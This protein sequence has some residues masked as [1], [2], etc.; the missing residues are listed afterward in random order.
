MH[1]IRY[2]TLTGVQRVGLLDGYGVVRRIAFATMAELLAAPLSE[3]R[4][5]AAEPTEVDEPAALLAP[6]APHTDVW[7]AGVTYLRSR[8]ARVEESRDQD[9]YMRVY[10]AVRPELFPKSVGWR[11]VSDGGSIGIRADSTSDIPEPELGL[12][13]NCRAEIIGYVVCNDVSSRAIEAEN[14]I[15]LPQAKIYA[16]SCA[17][18]NQIRPAWEVSDPRA[19]GIEMVVER[20]GLVVF[21]GMTSTSRMQRTFEDLVDHLFA[22]ADFPYGV[23]LSTGTGIVPPLDFTLATGDRVRISIEEVGSLT[24][25]VM[26]GKAAFANLHV[27]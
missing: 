10:D 14:P 24:S 8:D 1:L 3:I 26:L 20:A 6:L 22:A 11:V 2:A 21:R 13:L 4:A 25:E 7:A 23:V 18:S 5:A 15:Y 16:G 17:L 27:A 9:V 19:L 12:V